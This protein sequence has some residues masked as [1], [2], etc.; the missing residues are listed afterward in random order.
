MRIS[1]FGL[2]Y[3]GTVCAACLAQRGHS[4][5]GVDKIDTKVDLIRSGRSPVIE[6]EIDSIVATTVQSGH[7]TATV[8]AI[9]A[10]KSTDMSIVC[11]GTPRPTERGIG[12]HCGRGRLNRDWSGT[13]FKGDPS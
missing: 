13:S 11:V 2:G 3:V 9:E 6:R 10:V 7:L 4:V 1:V 5:I 8:D 12:P